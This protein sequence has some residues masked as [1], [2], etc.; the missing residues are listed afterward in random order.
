MIIGQ[1]YRWA[2]EGKS[3]PAI[4]RMLNA[5]NI[6]TPRQYW[7]LR[8]GVVSESTED[9]AWQARTVRKIL[10]NETYTGTLVQGKTQTTLYRRRKVSPDK[11]VRV[12][13]THPAIIE[14]ELFAAVQ[15]VMA[16]RRSVA[17]AQTDAEA[18]SNLFRGKVFCAH[19][20]KRMERKQSQAH[21]YY[22]CITKYTA[23]E[24]CPGCSIRADDLEAHVTDALLT[25]ADDFLNTQPD[26]PDVK[27][28]K[29]S[30]A[31]MVQIQMELSDEK[32]R[33]THWYEALLIGEITE[34]RFKE[35]M[36]ARRTAMDAQRNE[37]LRLLYAQT[38]Q[39]LAEAEWRE[40]R[41]A[42]AA[43]KEGP[44]LTRALVGGFVERVS[45]ADAGRV[46]VAVREGK[47]KADTMT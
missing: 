7:G 41:D 25:Y 35:L 12:E 17:L 26:F 23:P 2:G 34:M 19:C 42:L 24:H 39:K 14:P 29:E 43:F 40:R 13:Q 11:W 3:I 15:A 1:I 20:G 44:Q 8:S 22:R 6:L 5:A 37:W 46:F 47:G 4:V 36:D 33:L 28:T 30:Q 38:D 31:R 32:K 9:S 10:S 27:G 21:H 16:V 45:V 18:P